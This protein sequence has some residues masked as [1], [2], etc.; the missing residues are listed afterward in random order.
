MILSCSFTL[1]HSLKSL[2]IPSTVT[3]IVNAQIDNNTKLILK[4]DNFIEVGNYTLT[5]DGEM[6]VH[7]YGNENEYVLP[8][9]VKYVNDY[10]PFNLHYGKI[11]FSSGLLDLGNT[12]CTRINHI[13]IPEG[14]QTLPDM[15]PKN[16][17]ILQFLGETPPVCD[18]EI[19]I[20]A[21][22]ILIPSQSENIYKEYFAQFLTDKQMAKIQLV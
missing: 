12:A 16:C 14:M 1:C 22:K 8:E 13:V 15:K 20:N 4:G 5:A 6:V 7:Y 10:V 19:L 2:E 18:N 11:T 3:Q 9:T 21:E 17:E